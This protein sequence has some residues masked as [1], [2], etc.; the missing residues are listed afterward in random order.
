MR[1]GT[2]ITLA[3]LLLAL[4]WPMAAR[5]DYKAAKQAYYGC[6][7]QCMGDLGSLSQTDVQKRYRDCLQ[8][9]CAGAYQ[10]YEQ[11]YRDLCTS[12]QAHCTQCDGTCSAKREACLRNAHTQVETNN[13]AVEWEQCFEGCLLSR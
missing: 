9:T 13:C 4:A 7:Q 3:A 8:E 2:H 1:T 10:A 12:D 6:I 5:A 11:A